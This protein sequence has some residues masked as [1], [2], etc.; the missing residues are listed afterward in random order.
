M[1]L[2]RATQ[3]CNK[4]IATRAYSCTC[5]RNAATSRNISYPF[6]LAVKD[7][8]V[9]NRRHRRVVWHSAA[10]TDLYRITRKATFVPWHDQRV[11]G[12]G[13]KGTAGERCSCYSVFV[14][15]RKRHEQRLSAS[16]L[17]LRI[18]H[19]NAQ[20]I[21]RGTLGTRLGFHCKEARRLNITQE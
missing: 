17:A 19:E 15:E 16:K 9:V 5:N 1:P 18:R 21:A 7:H 6:S 11:L 12:Q 20:C 10:Q 3:V 2:Q 14:L 4:L 13:H 8:D